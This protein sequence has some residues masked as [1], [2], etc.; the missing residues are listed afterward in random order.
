M[1][2]CIVENCENIIV[3]KW[4]C[5]LHYQRNK[6]HGNTETYLLGDKRKHPLYWT[7]AD[8]KTRCYKINCKRYKN[9]GGR[10]IKICDRRLWKDWF[11]NFVEDMWPKPNQAYSLD[12]IDVNG[13][14]EPNNCKWSTQREQASNRSNNNEIVGVYEDNNWSTR[15]IASI[16]VK[17]K[18]ISLWRFKTKEEAIKARKEAENTFNYYI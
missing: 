6:R 18:N 1:T 9:Y 8:M 13:N 2:R 10:G 5:T 17:G 3:A 14:Y 11:Y 15:Y 7:H 12:R 16:Y 4:L